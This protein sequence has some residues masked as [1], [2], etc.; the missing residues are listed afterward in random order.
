MRRV[1]F[2]DPERGA[3]AARTLPVRLQ[4]QLAV[5]PATL[6]QEELGLALFRLLLIASGGALRA[7]LRH[8]E[9]GVAV[10]PGHRDLSDG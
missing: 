6:G 2:V 7:A 5:D 8:M 9:A 10:E 3:A 1:P 4:A